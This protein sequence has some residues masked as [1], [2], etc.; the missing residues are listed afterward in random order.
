[1]R[2]INLVRI[3]LLSLSC[4]YSLP[5]AAVQFLYDGLV[6]RWLWGWEAIRVGILGCVVE[7]FQAFLNEPWCSV[8]VVVTGVLRILIL[9]IP[10]G[11]K[12]F[13]ALA[14]ICGVVEVGI[15]PLKKI[16]RVI[17]DCLVGVIVFLPILRNSLSIVRIILSEI[18]LLD[19]NTVL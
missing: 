12:H 14:L 6:R 2:I 13:G 7:T 1:M 3:V 5:L 16:K 19:I 8:I 10:L 18:S 11:L 9:R 15:H 4:L 17:P